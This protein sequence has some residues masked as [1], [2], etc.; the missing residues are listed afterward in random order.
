[1]IRIGGF[2]A[3]NKKDDEQNLVSTDPVAEL[4]PTNDPSK[5]VWKELPPLP[6]PRSSTDATIIGD[7]LYVVGGWQLGGAQVNDTADRKW[8]ETG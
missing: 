2:A 1:L 6:E 8:H 4:I 7:D 5:N 3:T